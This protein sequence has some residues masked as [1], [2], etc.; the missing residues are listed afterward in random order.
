[1][2]LSSWLFVVCAIFLSP[3]FAGI[4][5]RTKAFFA[6]R[7]GVPL[8]QSY[9]DLWK[10]LHKSAV[11]SRTT[12]AV[13]WMGPAVSLAALLTSLLLLP[14]G[15]TPAIFSFPGSFVVFAYLLAAGRF[16]VMS[17]A[18]DTGSSFEGMGASREAQFGIFTEIAL[19]LALTAVALRSGS[20]SLSDMSTLVTAQEW[21]G[22]LAVYG[23]AGLVLFAVFLT[24]NARIPVDDPN[25][26]LELTMIHE[27]MVLD[28][29]GPDLGWILAADG[30]KLWIFGTLVLNA[31]LPPAL[32]HGGLDFLA[33]LAALA[34]LAVV[35]G[36]V[37]SVMARLRL[38]RIPHLL[39]GAV[40]IAVIAIGL[41]LR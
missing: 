36:A 21:T 31:V 20:F 8:L 5:H 40:A 7:S 25:T 18:L 22:N 1:V 32:A 38:G 35:T 4:I 29:G 17:A 3:L 13:F 2:L 19:F 28:H 41:A 23:L 12:S 9:Y 27:V 24:E 10:L 37:E 16:F 6:G 33:R 11:I 39:T 15:K 14:F 26:H 30:L 34:V